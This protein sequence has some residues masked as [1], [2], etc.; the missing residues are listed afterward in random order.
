MGWPL[1][2]VPVAEQLELFLKGQ[3]D[4]IQEENEVA[5]DPELAIDREDGDGNT[6]NKAN[7][8]DFPSVVVGDS[9][10]SPTTTPISQSVGGS[11]SAELKRL[12]LK[13]GNLTAEEEQMMM[14]H[15]HYT[16]ATSSIHPLLSSFINY[17][18]PVKFQGFDIAEGKSNDQV[19]FISPS[20]SLCLCVSQ[21]PCLS[22]VAFI[23]PVF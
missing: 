2:R 19:S 17:A 18:Q 7:N 12:Q 14:A 3:T 21:S 20:L 1:N 11:S 10:V 15:Y 4:A 13:K 6:E 9:A 23:F 5:E 16:G 22:V 8:G